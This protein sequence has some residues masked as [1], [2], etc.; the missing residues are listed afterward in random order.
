VNLKKDGNVIDFENIWYSNLA[1]TENV[2]VF[3][4]KDLYKAIISGE[5]ASMLIFYA[6]FALLIV[7]SSVCIY[8]IVTVQ[9]VNA[10]GKIAIVRAIGG[11]KK[12]ISGM[13]LARQVVYPLISGI[14]SVI[15]AIYIPIQDLSNLHPYIFVVLVTTLLAAVTYV[16]S[17]IQLRK[18]LNKPVLGEIG[19]M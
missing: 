15:M 17:D 5:N 1:N 3:C 4:L 9:M 19:R 7:I 6:L 8:N 13:I 10:R 14:S 12:K 11:T 18:E 2:N 16:I